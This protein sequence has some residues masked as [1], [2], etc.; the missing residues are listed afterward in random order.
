MRKSTP[1][2]MGCFYVCIV[3]ACFS[4]QK[5]KFTWVFCHL[6]CVILA[7]LQVVVG[8][9]W[10][11]KTLVYRQGKVNLCAAVISY[12]IWCFLKDLELQMSCAERLFF[13]KKSV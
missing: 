12:F 6:I 7:S 4:L 1:L 5:S 11:K 10:G 9:M 8:N 2:R 3:F 13:L